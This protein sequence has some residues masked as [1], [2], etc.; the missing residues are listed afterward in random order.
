MDGAADGENFR[1]RQMETVQWIG[2][3]LDR[4]ALDRVEREAL[5]FKSY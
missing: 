1:M 4:Y 5:L 3:L 2:C